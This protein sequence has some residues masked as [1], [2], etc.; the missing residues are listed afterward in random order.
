MAFSIPPVGAST[1]YASSFLLTDR[2]GVSAV[3]WPLPLVSAKRPR[4]FSL[5][6]KS[7]SELESVS[8]APCA[9]CSE[10]CRISLRLP[11]KLS[12]SD[13]MFAIGATDQFY[14]FVDV[15]DAGIKVTDGFGLFHHCFSGLL[16]LTA[17]ASA[18]AVICAEDVACSLIERVTTPINWVKR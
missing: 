11:R 9:F 1:F 2:T 15:V 10:M 13:R 6:R 8:R 3:A 14:L 18:A 4:R 16:R 5:L 12:D 7:D 17:H